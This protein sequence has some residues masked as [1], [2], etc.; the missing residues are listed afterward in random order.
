MSTIAYACILLGVA[1][2]NLAWAARAAEKSLGTEVGLGL[3]G[4]FAGSFASAAVA[5]GAMS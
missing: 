2:A 1:L 4:F 5:M 3:V